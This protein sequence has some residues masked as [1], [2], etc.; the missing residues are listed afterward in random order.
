MSFNKNACKR[1]SIIAGITRE[2]KDIT[3]IISDIVHSFLDR[4]IYN[5]IQILNF[6][7]RRTIT[8]QDLQFLLKLDNQFI[9][10]P[11]QL[12]K[13]IRMCTDKK[14]LDAVLRGDS[15]Y[16]VYT[17]RKPFNNLVFEICK[18]YTTDPPHFA[19]NVMILLQIL[20]EDLIIKTMNR[21]GIVMYNRDTLLIRDL[22][23]AMKLC[24]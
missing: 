20:T 23:L 21:A 15:G 18:D 6:C 24:P 1:L 12:T 16:K 14:D 2:N 10:C 3:T 11:E 17:L 5:L 8:V 7:N 19:K 13:L 9:I 4:M 22:E